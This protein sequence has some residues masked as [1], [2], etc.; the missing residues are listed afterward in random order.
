M[1][2][3]CLLN[4]CFKNESLKLGQAQTASIAIDE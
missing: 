2:D 1:A 3:V 4:D